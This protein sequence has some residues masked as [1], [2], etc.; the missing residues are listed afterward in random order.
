MALPEL[1]TLQRAAE[2]LHFKKVGDLKDLALNNKIKFIE[3]NQK[4]FFTEDHII[5]FLTR[6]T[7]K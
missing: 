5:D 4:I 3:I 7:S 1:L 6:N 2:Y